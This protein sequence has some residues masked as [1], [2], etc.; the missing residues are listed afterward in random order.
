M[1][2]RRERR[3]ETYRS[4][5]LWHAQLLARE[6]PH[7]RRRR[8]VPHGQIVRLFVQPFGLLLLPHLFVRHAEQNVHEGIVL[9]A[10]N[11]ERLRELRLGGL[12]IVAVERDI[13]CQIWVEALLCRG[14][15]RFT[16]EK[17]PCFG[18]L[19]LR[20]GG[21]AATSREPSECMRQT[22]VP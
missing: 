16:V 5:R 8:I 2:A 3:S 18:D 19:A 11:R 13:A 1:K 9:V 10:L 15:L 14:H 22:I 17:L 6:G 4:S 12:E 21:I 7:K 20:L